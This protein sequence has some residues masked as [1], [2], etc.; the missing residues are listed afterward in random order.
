MS[1]SGESK[2]SVSIFSR[3]FGKKPGHLGQTQDA[4][5]AA[6]SSLPL[7][8]EFREDI[9]TARKSVKRFLRFGDASALDAASSAWERVLNHPAFPGTEARFQLAAS[10]HAGRVLL[11]RYR[12]QGRVQDL[13]RALELWRQAV[14]LTPPDSPK[15]PGYLNNLGAGLSGRYERAGRLEDLEEAI[16]VYRQAVELTPADSPD[17]PGY[18]NNLGNG[19][20]NRYERAGRLEDLEE[21]I[22]LY[23]QAVKLVPADSPDMPGYLNNL[24]TGLSGRY[25]R[26]GRP[27][28]LEEAIGVYRRAV[29]LTPAD[30]PDLRIYLNNLDARLRNR[31]AHMAKP[32]DRPSSPAFHDT[33]EPMIE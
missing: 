24:G 10:N 22:G 5:G 15:L 9:R 16:G 8:P 31:S 4:P 1:R 3:L 6:A 28:D 11:R 12:A 13:D 29:K 14:K 7:P 30:S 32:A 25:E 21:A 27:E 33:E 2:S 26:A 20:R 23:R 17:M 18:L 19:L